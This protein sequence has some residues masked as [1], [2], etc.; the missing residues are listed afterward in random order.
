MRYGLSTRQGTPI[1]VMRVPAAPVRLARLAATRWLRSLR[2]T[3][4]ARAA[5]AVRTDLAGEKAEAA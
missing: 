3:L 2:S 1:E 5:S 4:E